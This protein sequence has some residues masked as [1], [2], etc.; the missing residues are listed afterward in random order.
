[1]SIAGRVSDAKAVLSAEII[2]DHYAYSAYDYTT[3]TTT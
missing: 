2:T 3:N 1:M